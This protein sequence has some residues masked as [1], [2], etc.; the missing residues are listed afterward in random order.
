MIKLS[1]RL[2]AICRLLEKTGTLADI[3]CDHG[4]ISV[5]AIQS[6][7]ADHCIAMDLRQGPLER[8]D[9]NIKKY[10][11]EDKIETRL[12]DGADALVPGEADSAVIAGM[13]GMLM[14]EILTRGHEVFSAMEQLVLQPQS[15]MEHFRS[16]LAQTGYKVEAEDIVIEEGKFY[17]MMR[18]R[19]TGKSYI[20]DSQQ[21]SYGY[22]LPKTGGE[23]MRLYLENERQKLETALGRLENDGRGERA[24]LR[25]KELKDRIRLNGVVYDAMLG[26]NGQSL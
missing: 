25:I 23:V 9:E 21:L 7:R 17:P 1:K 20:P 8:A 4:Y 10:S 13:G 19:F 12:S 24:A 16:F 15:D 18:A 6:G 22:M 26:S 5:Y 11:L 3:G 14:E 2:E